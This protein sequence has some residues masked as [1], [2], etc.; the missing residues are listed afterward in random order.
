MLFFLHSLEPFMFVFLSSDARE[1]VNLSACPP[2]ITLCVFP[3]VSVECGKRC[4]L[5]WR[6]SSGCI[7]PI[8]SSTSDSSSKLK[9][10]IASCLPA[11]SCRCLAVLKLFERCLSSLRRPLLTTLR[12]SQGASGWASDCHPTGR[13]P[14]VC[15]NHPGGSR[16][17]SGHGT[18][19]ADLQLPAG[20]SPSNQHL[21]LPHSGQFL[22][23]SAHRWGGSAVEGSSIREPSPEHTDFLWLC[24]CMLDG[25][26]YQEKVQSIMYLRHS[27][28]GGKSTSSSVVSLSPTVFTEGLHEGTATLKDLS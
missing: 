3:C 10:C 7:T 21:R 15:Q 9:S 13:L 16:V 19:E 2:S 8:R 27:S 12:L 17:S 18:S 23:L 20:R 5:P 25:K 24:R 28:S 1:A 11:R 26:L 14:V 22:L 4:W 6:S